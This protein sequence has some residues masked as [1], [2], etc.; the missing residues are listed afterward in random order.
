[1]TDDA[2][3]SELKNAWKEQERQKLI[4]SIP[5]PIPDLRDLFDYLGRENPPPCDHTLRETIEFL[6][7]RNLDVER[8]VPW[9]QK[10]GGYCDCEVIYNV[11][12][13]FGEIVGRG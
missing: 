4:A 3:K 5:M 8:I 11:E 6:K 7:Q 13:D 9:L 10:H 12:N 2:R 1:M